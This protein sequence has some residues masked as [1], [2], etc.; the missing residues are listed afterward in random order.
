MSYM[1]I[2]GLDNNGVPKPETLESLGL[3]NEP[4]HLL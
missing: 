2:R 4:T 3:E 1:N